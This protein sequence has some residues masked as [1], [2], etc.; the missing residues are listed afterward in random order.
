M[1]VV[2]ARAEKR[3]ISAGKTVPHVEAEFVDAGRYNEL[4]VYKRRGS[5]DD[6]IYIPTRDGSLAPYRL[7]DR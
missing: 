5:S 7:R 3:W 6:V 2:A 1:C 4:T